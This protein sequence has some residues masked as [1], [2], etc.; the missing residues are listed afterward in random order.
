MNSQTKIVLNDYN[1]DDFVDDI[2]DDEIK[3]MF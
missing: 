3:L 1:N 2:D